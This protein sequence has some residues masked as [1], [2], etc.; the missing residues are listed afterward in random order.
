MSVA[1]KLEK[2][3][4]DYPLLNELTPIDAIYP[5]G[6]VTEL[7]TRYLKY[8]PLLLQEY[9]KIVG[10]LSW[11]SQ[12]CRPDICPAINKCA[13]GLVAPQHAHLIVLINIL[14]Y[15]KETSSWC[16]KYS[17]NSPASIMLNQMSE[18]L[19]CRTWTDCKDSRSYSRPTPTTPPPS[20]I[21]DTVP[22]P[23]ISASSTATSSIGVTSVKRRRLET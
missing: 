22:S 18:H 13:S 17:N 10:L 4:E 5:A 20:T 21:L 8:V 9:R 15:V 16:L 19:Q 14:R 7:P 3:F 12:A 1:P 11:C 2:I 23:G 6:N